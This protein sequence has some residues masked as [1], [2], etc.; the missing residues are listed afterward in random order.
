MADDIDP[1][2]FTTLY[3]GF[4]SNLSP[5]TLQSRCPGSLYVGFAIL[6]GYKFIISEVGFGNIIPAEAN[7]VVYG[8]LYFLTAAHEK[9]LDQAEMHKVDGGKKTWHIKRR[10]TVRRVE[11]EIDGCTNLLGEV[12]A[13]TYIDVDHTAE[14]V[15]SKENLTFLRRAVDDGVQSGI[16]REHFEKYWKN[17]LPEDESVG[18]QE[19]ITMVRTG[20]MDREDSSRYVPKEMLRMAGKD[21]ISTI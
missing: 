7:D 15:V 14:G 19:T 18:R 8:S 16:P 1:T 21:E 9:S 20:A 6:W 5:R 12:E 2:A 4:A 13:M 17:Y 10:L 3:F 11:S